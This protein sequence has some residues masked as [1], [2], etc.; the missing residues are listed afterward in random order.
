MSARNSAKGLVVHDGKLLV[1]RCISRFGE[2]YALPGGGQNTGEM[3]SET[4]RREVL[5]ETGLTLTDYR[6]RGVV[7]FLS[8]E[9]EGEYM[10]LYT[11]TGFTGDLIECGEGTLEWVPIEDAEKLPIWEGDKIFFRLLAEE[12]PPFLLKLEYSGDLL[13]RAVLDGRELPI[14]GEKHDDEV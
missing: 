10:Y 1:N 12:H 5:E 2:Y 7:T 13:V 14:K 8:D 3:L 4:V 9:W 6:C 11:A